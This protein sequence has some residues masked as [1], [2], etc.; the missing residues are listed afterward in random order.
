MKKQII[1]LVLSVVV[2]TS[3]PLLAMEVEDDQDTPSVPHVP[4]KILRRMDPHDDT[5]FPP[6]E[7]EVLNLVKCFYGNNGIRVKS[8]VSDEGVF[9]SQIHRE[10][11]TIRRFYPES[12]QHFT[13]QLVGIDKQAGDWGE[14]IE[15]VDSG[16]HHNAFKEKIYSFFIGYNDRSSRRL[17]LFKAVNK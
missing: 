17:F 6:T 5:S 2:G 4:Q 8:H 14:P 7:E 12:N 13:W 16:Y 1:S 11:K 3:I 15:A 9:M 10:Y